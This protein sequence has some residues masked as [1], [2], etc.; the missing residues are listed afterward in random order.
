MAATSVHAN[1]VKAQAMQPQHGQGVHDGIQ[2]HFFAEDKFFSVRVIE[3]KSLKHHSA[4]LFDGKAREVVNSTEPLQRLGGDRYN[5]KASRFHIA[6][7]DTGGSMGVLGDGGRTEFE[8]KFTCPVSFNWTF[9]GGPAIHQAHIR[10]EI[11]YG[12]RTL[13]AIGYSKR[14]W[15]HQDIGYWA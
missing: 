5:V 10:A 9:P 8:L 14:Y 1:A 4:W 7:T 2:Y 11:S 3:T 6:T 12:G 15:Y 13:N